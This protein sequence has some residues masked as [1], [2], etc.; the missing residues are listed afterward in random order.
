MKLRPEEITAILKDR[1]R[2]FEVET[3]LS[4]VGT[5]LQV[6]DGIARI[7]GLE[8]CVSLERLELEHGVV[9]I[10]FNLEEDNVGTALFGEWQ[11]VKEGQL[12][13]RT[14]DVM[15]VPVGPGLLG[16]VVDPLGNPLDGLGP[17][18]A[19]DRRPLEFKA[20]G[21]ISRQP[22]KEP[23]QTG[24]KSI[25]S[26][27]PVGRGQRELIIGDRSTGKTAIAVDTILNQRGGDVVCIY[28]AIGQKGSTVAQV[29]ERLRDAGAMEYTIVVSASAQEAAP[30][31][32]MA[33]F[34]GCA[35]GEYFLYSGQH[36]LCIYD[37]LSK[38]ADSYRQLSLL[39][40]RPPGREAFPGDVFYLHSR[41]LERACKLS[42]DLG[43]GSL[44]ALPVIETQAG[45]I[46]AYIPTNV[47]S[48]TDGQIFLEAS[49]F[50]SGVRPAI[51]VGTSVSRVGGNAQTKAMK[52]VAGRL[53]LDLA[54]YRELEAFSQ[55]GS[56][57]DATTQSAL[58]RG[59]R[60]VATLNQP[61]Y[62]P[63]PMEEQVVGIYSGIHGWLDKIPVNQV[64]RFHDELREH[65]R[66][67]GA[68]LEAIRTTGDL[69]DD[70]AAKLQTELER[71]VHGFNIEEEKGLAG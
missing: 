41:L 3:D 55:F 25:D 57:L 14:G 40:R 16:R 58:A 26:M 23:L 32:W 31:K 34:A 71:F 10:A 65:L 6:G 7:H 60:M 35:M 4:E 51:N 49:L 13:R 1:I 29:V 69:S 9:G 20:P 5:V 63:W 64:S 30:I 50:F 59:E 43:G 52:K 42:D 46:A 37:D 21:V 28:V 48:I 54:Q 70:V 17:I 8:N 11:R 66:T 19:T 18:E 33:P 44:T 45:D 24:I 67:E 61:Q 39:L 36:A 22:V 27:T 15:S 68:I 2:E 38:H 53:R 56:E 12:V 62:Q 47:I